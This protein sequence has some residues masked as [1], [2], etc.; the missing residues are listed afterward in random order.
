M[1]MQSACVARWPPGGPGGSAATSEHGWRAALQQR[2][3]RP[4]KKRRREGG[5]VSAAEGQRGGHAAL[6]RHAI[7]CPYEAPGVCPTSRHCHSMKRVCAHVTACGETRS[8]PFPFCD[9]VRSFL[10]AHRCK[11]E[12]CLPCG[13]AWVSPEGEVPADWR[14]RALPPQWY[15]GVSPGWPVVPQQARVTDADAQCAAAL[16]SLAPGAALSLGLAAAP[17]V[18]ESDDEACHFPFLVKLRQI[19]SDPNNGD[20]ISWCPERRELE[21]LDKVRLEIEVMPKFFTTHGPRA[22]FASFSR[23]LN[24]YGFENTLKGRKGRPVYKHVDPSVVTVDDFRRVR[25][26]CGKSARRQ[27]TLRP[28]VAAKDATLVLSLADSTRPDDDPDPPLRKLPRL[29]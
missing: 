18:D 15:A 6:L 19:V 13:A 22:R 16:M 25:K 7:S 11:E 1:M 2:Q 5:R 14:P 24:N 29:A 20:I 8:C 28:P 12:S 17:G 10:A 27:A 4:T 23:Q 3:L 21:I 9:Y 26:V